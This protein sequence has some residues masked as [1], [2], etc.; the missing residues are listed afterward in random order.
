MLA[1]LL[2]LHPEDLRVVYRH[3]PL[4]TLFDKTSQAVQAAEAAGA[5]GFFWEMH[6]ILFER[7]RQWVGLS[8]EDF[9]TWLMAMGIEIGL[10]RQLFQ[11]E[12]ESDKYS[13]FIQDAFNSGVASGILGTPFI[14]VNHEPFQQDPNFI[15]LE[16]SVRIELMAGRQYE[17]YPPMVI[18]DETA[19]FAHIL[20]SSGEIIIQLFPQET[21]LAVNN[22]IFLARDGWFNGNPLHY[23]VS[24]KLVA[25]GDPSGTGIG[26]PGYHFAVEINE[27]ITFDEAGVVAFINAGPDTNGSQ[28]FF[29]L[30]PLPEMN[31]KQTIFGRVTQGFELLQTLSARHPIEDLLTPPE[32]TIQS[33]T[34]EER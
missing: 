21:P 23:V 1:Q 31:D 33:V 13:Q 20:L 10:D 28:F 11:D 34:I 2:E 15:N 27:T 26:D 6:D 19:Y 7:H 17:N 5:Q 3:F 30:S 9:Q 29:T 24:E 4:I 32:E 22:F 18:S 8:Q 14:L 25:S 12:L 16:A